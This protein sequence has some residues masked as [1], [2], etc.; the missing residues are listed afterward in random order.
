MNSE[1]DRKLSLEELQRL[2]MPRQPQVLPPQ[3]QHPTAR[4]WVELS[5]ALEAIGMI[6]ADQLLALDELAKRPASWPRQGQIAE[7]LQEMKE[8]HS[9]LEQAGKKKERRFLLPRLPRI[10]LPRPSWTWLIVPAILLGLLML[11]YSS[12]ALWNGLETLFP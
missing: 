11:W 9:L 5:A 6:L 1:F 8:M 3:E 2:N 10:Y 7:L 12:A 4:E